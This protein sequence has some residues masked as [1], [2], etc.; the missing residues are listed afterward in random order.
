[1]NILF[2]VHIYYPSIGGTEEY[3]HQCAKRLVNKGHNVWVITSNRNYIINEKYNLENEFVDGVKI[4]RVPVL[5]NRFW[6]IPL[7]SP[8]LLF[9]IY[10]FSDLIHLHGIRYLVLVALFVKYVKRIPVVIGSYG[11]IFHTKYLPLIKEFT[12]KYFFGPLISQF[13][14]LHTISKQD[15]ELAKFRIKNHPKIFEM[16]GGIEFSIKKY[17]YHKHK[18]NIIFTWGRL[19][20]HKNIESLFYLLSFYPKITLRIAFTGY[21]EKYYSNIKKLIKNHNVEKQVIFLGKLNYH[22]LEKEILNSEAVVLPSN[23]EGFGLTAIEAMK[24]GRMVVANDIIAYRNIISHG[25][26]GLIT[27]FNNPKKLCSFWKEYFPCS[28]DER[29][30]LESSA[31]KT[32]LNYDWDPKVNALTNEYQSIIRSYK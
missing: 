18:Q 25:I 3:S 27:N 28:Y 2:A 32:S 1:M 19:S 23:Y 9:D 12:F 4:T 5:Y 14:L 30:I 10:R 16:T 17:V 8:S 7:I 29:Y 26:N 6:P 20:P 13:D 31:F 11:Y 15:T 24:I 22:D 21:E